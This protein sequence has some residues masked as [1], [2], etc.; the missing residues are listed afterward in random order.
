[1]AFDKRSLQYYR[2][3]VSIIVFLYFITFE[4]VL[5]KKEN[6]TCFGELL[7]RKMKTEEC[8]VEFK[9]NF[10]S[11]MKPSGSCCGLVFD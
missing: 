11:S 7:F 10:N 4:E 1:M 6:V 9:L 8:V 3:N 5:A 2:R